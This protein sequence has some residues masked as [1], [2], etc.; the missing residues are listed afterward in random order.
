MPAPRSLRAPLIGLLCLLPAVAL[1]EASRQNT[2]EFTLDNG[3]KLVVREDH[4]AP[5]AVVQLWYRVGSSQE[6][7]G[8][9]GLSHALEHLMFKGSRKLGA[10]EASHL[11][12]DL[13]AEENAFTTDDYTVYYQLLARDRLPVALELE[14]DRMAHLRLAP[15]EITRELE[16]IKEERRLRTDDRPEALSFE[17]FK[18]AA[19]PASGYR[20]PTIGWPQDLQRLSA[21]ELQRWYQTWYAPNNAT[22]VV[23]GDVAPEAVKAE[24][25]R[26]FGA[27]PRSDLPA[28]KRPLEL[29]APG[30]R[31]LALQAREV[32][33][34]LMG[35]NVPGLATA[36]S[37]RDAYALQ[38]LAALLGGGA[39]ARLPSR[40]ERG[41][42]LA[43]SVRAAYGA[44]TNGDS[45]FL[46]SGIP[47]PQRGKTLEQLEA[48][49][50]EQLE[51]LK[52]EAPGAEE[53][54]RVRALL[55]AGLVYGRDSITAQASSIGQLES[56]GLGWRQGDR[57]L[58][59]LGKVTPDDLRRV[60]RTYFTRE[61]LTLA[62]LRPEPAAEAS[63]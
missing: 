22:L 35:F 47:N 25:Q 44:Y 38:L 42:E 62:Q 2:A 37:P 6:A 58:D 57:L 55:V 19:Y 11:L 7:P 53:V 54:A 61:R 12:R 50:W 9:T 14:A 40:L 52:R 39:G 59:E 30:E 51:L 10:G 26:W 1:A 18:A 23:V 28:S 27:I 4:R 16:V 48:A 31:R 41:Q 13:G 56:I 8:A 5:V 49:F 15:D 63:R 34:L 20:N 3:L 46:L 24:V 43:T 33:S 32:P 36:A 29:P 21:A 60:A 17:R 45:L